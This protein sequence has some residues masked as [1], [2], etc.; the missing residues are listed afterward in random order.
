L[1]WTVGHLLFLTGL[2]L[3]AP[4][5]LGLYHLVPTTSRA[6]RLAALVTVTVA[7]VG[8]LV[9]VRV[10]LIDLV[11]GLRAADHQAMDTLYGQIGDF[12]GCCRPRSTALVHC[13]SRSV[14]PRS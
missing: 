9:F 13:S 14:W 4:V 2:L 1:A 8:L 12:P 6:R 5:L 7:G 10:A 3:F 11:V